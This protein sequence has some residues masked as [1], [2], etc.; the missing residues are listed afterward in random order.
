M[1]SVAK[2]FEIKELIISLI[3]KQG[4]TYS[5]INRNARRC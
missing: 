4:M 1:L 2:T 5:T 3:S